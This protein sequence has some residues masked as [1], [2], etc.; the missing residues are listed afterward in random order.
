M[1]SRYLPYLS[2]FLA[3]ALGSQQCISCAE[4]QAHSFIRHEMKAVISSPSAG[5]Q[6]PAETQR[7]YAGLKGSMQLVSGSQVS[8][9]GLS[10][11]V[12]ERAKEGE[13]RTAPGEGCQPGAWAKLQDAN[14][15]LEAC[16]GRTLQHWHLIQKVATSVGSSDG[17]SRRWPVNPAKALVRVLDSGGRRL[18]S[19]LHLP[20]AR[21]K[22]Q[23]ASLSGGWV[24]REGRAV[25]CVHEDMCLSGVV[26]KMRES[27]SSQTVP[28]KH[29]S[30][31]FS[32]C[33]VF[34]RRGTRG[35]PAGFRSGS[36]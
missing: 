21:R 34:D 9:S 31:C 18:T 32:S 23:R 7:H 25:G 11:S 6:H 33:S 12:T 28:V 24:D 27:R 16:P 5:S 2:L 17:W 29:R 3:S 1:E 19:E 26:E 15:C 13:P 4:S 35:S 8:L 20:E 36:A 22:A 30:L 14:D 10:R